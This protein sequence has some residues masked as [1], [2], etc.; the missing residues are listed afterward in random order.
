MNLNQ[1]F[2]EY[3]ADPVPLGEAALVLLLNVQTVIKKSIVEA[4]LEVALELALEV[5]LEVDLEVALEIEVLET[6]VLETE[7]LEI[8]DLETEDLVETKVLEVLEVILIS[9]YIRLLELTRRPL[10]TFNLKV[11]TYFK[12]IHQSD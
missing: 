10:K 5:F 4:A 8:E 11:S 1:Y 2:Q 3:L 9:N 6:K 12:T 7:G